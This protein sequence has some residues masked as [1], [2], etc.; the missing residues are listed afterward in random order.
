MDFNFYRH[1]ET[2]TLAW[3]S[4]TGSAKRGKCEPTVYGSSTLL[5]T[6]GH[7]KRIFILLFCKTL[8]PL[9]RSFAD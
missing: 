2:M 5:G 1:C 9:L 7:W 4:R 8:S 3:H 6:V